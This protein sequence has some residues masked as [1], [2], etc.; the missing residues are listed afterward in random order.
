[1]DAKKE[2][3]SKTNRIYLFALCVHPRSSISFILSLLLLYF[4][5]QTLLLIHL[6]IEY[7]KFYVRLERFTLNDIS[8]FFIYFSIFCNKSMHVVG[9]VDDLN[10]LCYDINYLCTRPDHPEFLSYPIAFK[11]D[12]P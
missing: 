2:N 7:Q 4:I 5:I 8:C 12:C 6:I 1:M 3:R 9:A 11:K 10:V